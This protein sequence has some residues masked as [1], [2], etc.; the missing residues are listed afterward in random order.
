MNKKL[1]PGPI[2]ETPLARQLQW[3]LFMRL[4]VISVLLGLSILLQSPE[5]TLIRPP[6]VYIAYFIIGVYL[7]TLFSALLTKRVGNLALFANF[8][9]VADTVL[10]TCLVFFSGSS[11]SVF[12]II[13]F[14][15]IVAG[16]I[17]LQRKGSFVPAACSALGYTIALSAEY[18]GYHP[19]YFFSY[20]YQ[21]FDDFL[22]LLNNVIIYGM[23][24][25]VV[26]VLSSLLAER[27]HKAERALSRT[28][29]Q[30]DKLAT[31]YERIFEDTDTGIITLDST[32]R[33]TSFNPAFELISG[34]AAQEV[35]GQKVEEKFPVIDLQKEKNI[36]TFA[37][38]TRKNGEQ[39]A[40]S[41]SCSRLNLPGEKGGYHVITLQDLSGIKRME[42]QLRQ[43]EKMAAIGEM[44]AGVAHEFRNP[45]AVISGS[46]EVLY[47]KYMHDPA[48]NS[49]LKIMV[50][51]SQ[52]LEDSISDFLQFSKPASPEKEWLS[53]EKLAGEA[54]QLLQKT[55]QWR[56]NCQLVLDIPE[57]MD[58]W[59]DA[60]HLRRVLIN[61][62][63]NS[64]NALP[65]DNGKI[66][67]RAAETDDDGVEKTIIEVSDNGRGIPPD[68]AGKIFEPFFT[69]NAS[70]I[71]L[72]LA[73]VSQLVDSHGGQISLESSPG[74][75]TTIRITLPLPT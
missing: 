40:V 45:L 25:F 71:G 36:Q 58:C 1:E 62:I 2:S 9:V 57:K 44:A 34:F 23:A 22:L 68:I 17:V 73:I 65:E 63:H 33:I 12:T 18:L 53:I 26:A 49:L 50:R 54:V 6:Y 14:F 47:E 37:Y 38:L 42:D 35:L 15:P 30:F 46:A 10:I 43:V 61:L 69:T 52:R 72:G 51:E 16:S 41:Y 59:G 74:A 39:I 3:L 4:V 64:L 70:G 60:Q 5:S 24:F 20:Y 29:L 8:Q 48:L 75:G 7:F 55:P 19:N 56:P 67:V 28:T 32:D 31:L 21:P 66:T 11:Q 27:L 13:Y